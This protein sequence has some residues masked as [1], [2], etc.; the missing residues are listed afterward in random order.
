MQTRLQRY[1]KN[2]EKQGYKRVSFFV[3]K[4]V[5]RYFKRNSKNKN[6]TIN[7]YLKYLLDF[8]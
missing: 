4:K 2:K 8:K 3:E 1:I 6:M 5:W 7:D